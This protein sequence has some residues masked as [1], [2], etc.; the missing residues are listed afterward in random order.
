MRL[1]RNIHIHN[2]SLPSILRLAVL[3]VRPLW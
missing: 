2:H 1:P 3:L